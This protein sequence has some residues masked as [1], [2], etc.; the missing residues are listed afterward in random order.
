MAD[1]VDAGPGAPAPRVTAALCDG[2]TTTT[3]DL[4]VEELPVGIAPRLCAGTNKPT[5]GGLV[6]EDD[7]F[8]L[9]VTG[10]I[11]SSASTPEFNLIDC[12]TPPATVLTVIDASDHLWW[13]G[14]SVADADGSDVTP[15]ISILEGATIEV[16]LHM[17][18]GSFA[19]DHALAMRDSVG[20]LLAVEELTG[21]LLP[22]EALSG[23]SVQRGDAVG[24]LTDGACGTRQGHAEVFSA[25]TSITLHPGEQGALCSDGVDIRVFAGASWVP[26][27]WECTDPSSP[28]AWIAWR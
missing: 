3:A 23:F 13:F 18:R 17:N 14:V 25:D 5:A 7:A 28:F 27:A 11:S 9:R 16:F 19:G 6:E 15:P 2:S 10:D 1:V 20:L 8:V 22:E 24:P 12:A 4:S 21:Q 26:V